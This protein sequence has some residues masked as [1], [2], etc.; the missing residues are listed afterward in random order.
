[1][2]KNGSISVAFSKKKNKRFHL[3]GSVT[4]NE[5]KV[6]QKVIS[7]VVNGT[8]TIHCLRYNSRILDISWSATRYK[9]KVSQN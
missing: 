2:P 6:L 8:D 5:I 7:K 9:I 1:M 4:R 3:L